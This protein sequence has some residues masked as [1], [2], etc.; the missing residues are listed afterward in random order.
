MN[1]LAFSIGSSLVIFH[2]S[3]FYFEVNIFI[4]IDVSPLKCATCTVFKVMLP[5][6][7]KLNDTHI[8]VIFVFNA[9]KHIE[10]L[11][12]KSAC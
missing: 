4:P 3:F 11:M 2:S 7:Y 9:N 12:L 1:C 6:T 8:T 10:Y 5:N